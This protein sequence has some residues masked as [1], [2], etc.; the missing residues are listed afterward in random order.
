MHSVQSVNGPDV[1]T[2]DGNVSGTV[3]TCTNGETPETV[4]EGFTIT[5][6]RATQGGAMLCVG[7]SPTVRDC[8][9]EE[10]EATPATGG[11]FTGVGGVGHTPPPCRPI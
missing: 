6:G 1:T 9:F 3:V 7:S 8:V 10:N 5:A 2:I 11:Q 4:L